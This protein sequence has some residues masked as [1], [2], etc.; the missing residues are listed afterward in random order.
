[1]RAVLQGLDP[2]DSWRRYL[3][4]ADARVDLR[5]VK[6]TQQWI[7]DEFAAAAQREQRPG[8]ARLV[9]LDARQGLLDA[10]A[11]PSLEDFV[12]DAGLEDFAQSE[13]IQAYQARYGAL[14]VR[15]R[16]SQR[17][18]DR[19][20]AALRWLETLAARAP[21]PTDPVENWLHPLLADKLAAAGFPTLNALLAHIH[22]RGSLWHRG[23]RGIG[24]GKASRIVQWLRMQEVALHQP[25]GAHA[26]M[27]RRAW[28]TELRHNIVPG[29]LDVLP[30]E[31]L[32]LPHELSGAQ[33]SNRAPQGH[34]Q[35]RAL[36]DLQALQCWLGPAPSPTPSTAMRA[37]SGTSPRPGHTYRAYRKEAERLLLWAV[38]ERSKPLSSLDADDAL[39]YL[40]FLTHPEPAARW[41]S[42]Q[43]HERWSP[44]WRPFTGPLAPVSVAHAAR[45]L[46]ALF[47]FLVAQG[48]LDS[49]LFD[50]PMPVFPRAVKERT[51]TYQQPACTTST[52]TGNSKPTEPHLA[53]RLSICAAAPRLR[54]R[55]LCDARLCDL[56]PDPIDPSR[57]HLQLPP[58]RG[59]LPPR[60][61]LPAQAVA[62]LQARSGARGWPSGAGLP[63]HPDWHVF[64]QNPRAP[65]LRGRQPATPGSGILP[66]TL[67][68]QLRGWQRRSLAATSAVETDV[69]TPNAG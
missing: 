47:R 27:P 65:K 3:A 54:L 45:V 68:D 50:T 34:C 63:L 35:I 10:P 23:I 64:E 46:R 61:A 22:A 19:Q 26:D 52:Q 62:L 31:K 14:A 60:I 36:D 21:Q 9:L 51:L 25:L 18:L 29:G 37:P 12:A 57:W 20:L 49:A 56:T 41:C 8:T 44:A 13:Q 59:R 53:L 43:K 32:R 6:A 39:A 42:P 4:V 5:L 1:M 15:Q 48:Y 33:G 11:L 16:R 66:G 69:I 40:H 24:A 17:L 38:L 58:V 2:V 28:S 55:Q 7:R 67:R 30:I